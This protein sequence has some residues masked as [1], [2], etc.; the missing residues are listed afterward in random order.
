MKPAFYED[1]NQVG[2]NHIGLLGFNSLQLKDHGVLGIWAAKGRLPLLLFP[3]DIPSKPEGSSKGEDHIEGPMTEILR[4]EMFKDELVTRF[5]AERTGSSF[6]D[7]LYPHLYL[8][9]AQVFLSFFF[10]AGKRMLFR[11]SR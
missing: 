1:P 7:S 2:K 4:G 8:K 10:A 5:E 6:Q 11:I 9:A 3:R